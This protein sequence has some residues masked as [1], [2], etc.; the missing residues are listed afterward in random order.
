MA[1][2]WNIIKELEKCKGY[3]A[4]V[5]TTFNFDI[6]Y[7]ENGI[8]RILEGRGIKYISILN[9]INELNKAFSR[10]H[11]KCYL[12]KHYS[13]NPIHINGAVH[14][15]IILLFSKEKYRLF[16]SS[17][18]LTV[19][20]YCHNNE[21]FN[22][23]EYDTKKDATKNNSIIIEDAIDFVLEMFN[24]ADTKD[25][26]I[27]NYLK[28]IKLQGKTSNRSDNIVVNNLKDSIINQITSVDKIKGIDVA[29]PYYDKK[30]N[31]LNEL[32]SK[33]PKAK[34]N[35]FLQKSK[36]RIDIKELRK[37]KYKTTIYNKIASNNSAALCHGKIIRLVGEKNEYLL[38]GSANCTS[39]ALLKTY[40]NG[41]NIEFDMLEKREV[42][43]SNNLFDEFLKCDDD[44]V[45]EPLSFEDNETSNYYYKYGTLLNNMQI[46]ICIGY[47]KEQKII[48]I[49]I[50]NE[51]CDY[52]IDSIKKEIKIKFDID[53]E[54]PPELKIEIKNNKAIEHIN[55]W[56]TN[57]Y[58]LDNFRLSENFNTNSLDKFDYFSEDDKYCKD[59]MALLQVLYESFDNSI[60]KYYNENINDKTEDNIEDEDINTTGIIDDNPEYLDLNTKDHE[61]HKA[62]QIIEKFY[63]G[64]HFANKESN[65][66]KY[67]DSKYKKKNEIIIKRHINRE[68]YTYE[69]KFARFIRSTIDDLLY[70]LEWKFEN[71]D[72]CIDI[73]KVIE[74]IYNK[75]T[76]MERVDG[77]FYFDDISS[78]KLELVEKLYK[79]IENNKL[80]SE[81]VEKITSI[82]IDFI[83]ENALLHD[84]ISDVE[85]YNEKIANIFKKYK[86]FDK[87]ITNNLVNVIEHFNYIRENDFEYYN[88]LIRNHLFKIFK[89]NDVETLVNEIEK[90]V[91]TKVKISENNETIEIS[92]KIPKV[93]FN[94]PDKKIIQILSRYI[95]YNNNKISNA[96]VNISFDDKT[97][98]VKKIFFEI[99]LA[100]ETKSYKRIICRKNG[101]DEID[102]GNYGYGIVI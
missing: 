57:N 29:A 43:F 92:Y 99:N 36:A 39:S 72:K 37:A 68:M 1:N 4:A 84:D 97:T 91:R 21:I 27:I 70:T 48:E 9:D 40:K 66:K 62:K 101:Q 18:N 67:I 59:R 95:K 23:Y 55:G 54:F 77:L 3:D 12:G 10:A 100:Y 17:A 80:S 8:L 56:Y 2:K 42:S 93:V 94:P 63:H 45:F 69:K 5:L 22:D 86:K 58:L 64:F 11:K 24:I 38:F 78:D 60:N 25:E 79:C 83:I 19:S 31:A 33:F 13:V 61:F 53:G 28:E 102:F 88:D 49:S 30:L 96:K 7:F 16:V 32:H 85:V 26:K 71:F 14:P 41:G 82:C 50:N 20:G 6:D 89:Y 47:I 75:Y 51:I 35:L 65:N 73:M 90:I 76:L 15:K 52:E 46:D 34:I 44:S 74:E 98:T 81:Y 87:N